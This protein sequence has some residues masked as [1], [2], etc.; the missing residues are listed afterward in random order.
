MNPM[1]RSSRRSNPVNGAFRA[2]D[3][4]DDPEDP[5]E[6][7]VC[8]AVGRARRAAEE[9]RR[10]ADLQIK[11]ANEAVR[12]ADEALEAAN[13][14]MRATREKILTD[15]AAQAFARGRI[16]AEE[17]AFAYAT[18]S[19]RTH[20]AGE[21]K[22]KERMERRRRRPEGRQQLVPEDH[23]LESRE[24][25]K[26]REEDKNGFGLDLVVDMDTEMDT[27]MEDW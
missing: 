8:Q 21:R 18:R 1:D 3:E 24:Q 7:A 20:E 13:R 4:V 19:E 12:L 9:A 23:R 10:V 26:K 22:R 5:L 14:A 27:D 11:A 16:R 17:G 15:Q 2:D 25:V 6:L